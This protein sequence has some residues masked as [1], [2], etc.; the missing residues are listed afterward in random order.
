MQ[1]NRSLC[2]QH[3]K[4]FSKK[5]QIKKIDA[6]ILYIIGH[7]LSMNGQIDPIQKRQIPE[8]VLKR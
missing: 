4:D 7:F 3:D 6:Q 2:A 5:T 8:A 1:R